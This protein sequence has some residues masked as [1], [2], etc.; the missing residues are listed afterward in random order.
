MVTIKVSFL[1]LITIVFASLYFCTAADETKEQPEQPEQPAVEN[2]ITE[3][4]PEENEPKNATKVENVIP[5]VHN[6]TLDK[7]PGFF[8][9]E[10]N[11]PMLKRGFYVMLVAM[12]LM[13]VYMVVK[14]YRTKKRKTKRY[15]LLG[16]KNENI[17]LNALQS[18][19]EDDYTV[20]EAKTFH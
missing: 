1:Y 4:K 11:Y 7:V 19:S 13:M 20:F 12:S 6:H 15:G 8:N 2:T 10:N 9:M 14:Y 17:E 3:V 18:D 5:S 16:S